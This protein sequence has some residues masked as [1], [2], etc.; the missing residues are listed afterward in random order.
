[1]PAAIRTVIPSRKIRQYQSFCES[2]EFKPYT[3]L[4]LF[5]ILDACFASKQ[6]TLQGLDYIAKQKVSRLLIS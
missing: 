6:V 1:M 3:D 2:V 5:R 4:T